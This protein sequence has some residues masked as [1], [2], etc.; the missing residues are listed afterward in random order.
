MNN[1]LKNRSGF[2]NILGIPNSGKSTLI[3]KLVGKKISIVSHKVQT[4]R[5]CIKGIRMCNLDDNVQSQ[6]I[7]I[8]T[9]GIFDAKRR[10]DKAMVSAAYSELNH[11]DKV[12]F[13]HD[14]SKANLNDN[15]L[16]VIENI[17]K[18]KSKVILVLNK[19]DLCPKDKLLERISR[20]E[21]LFKFEKVFLISAK[22][23]SGC[24]DLLSYLANLMPAHPFLYDKDTIS[25]LPE[26]L[27]ASEITREKLFHTLN[28]ELPYNLMVETENWILNDDKSINIDQV[29]YVNKESHKPIVLGKG[30]QNI[31]R[32]GMTSRK[33]LEELLNCKIHLF[34]FVKY[35]KNW[36]EDPRKYSSIGLDFNA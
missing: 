8:D 21:E 22:N 9:P 13:I 31:K 34:L 2:V 18:I 28:Q 29:I 17:L 25:D 32:V 10:L 3:N 20:I 1:E 5:F 35:K 19:I 15:S 36:M 6:I 27:L 24:E 33:E 30:G 26:A 23:G 16:K 11:T 7:F 12:I 4:T 14:I